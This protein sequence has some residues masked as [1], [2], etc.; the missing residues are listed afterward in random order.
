MMSEYDPAIAPAAGAQPRL[1]D[2][3]A[4]ALGDTAYLDSGA[5]HPML[6]ASRAAVA[7]YLAVRSLVGADMPPVAADRILARF[8]AL[9]NAQPDEVAFVQSTTTAEHLIVDGL[10]L[11]DSDAHI[12]TDTLHFVGSIPLYDGLARR[13]AHV[14]WVRP[15]DGRILL[16]DFERALTAQ[17]S[18][19]AL[20]SVSSYNGFEHDLAAVCKLAHAKGAL[21]YADIV[22]SAGCV[23]IDVAAAGVDF[24]AC[25]S[26]KWLMGEFGLGFVYISSKAASRLRRK[27]YG[28]GGAARFQSHIYPLDPPG[29]GIADVEMHGNATGCFA[30]GAYNRVAAIALDQSTAFIEQLGVA[31]INAHACELTSCLKE[32]LAKRGYT[33]LTPRESRAPIV[34]CLMEDAQSLA[35]RLAE[36]GVR[37]TLDRNRFRVSPSIF[38]NLDDVERLLGALPRN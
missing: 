31:R 18:F 14:S 9:I 2:R 34:T 28:Y 5:V 26:Y 16:E 25:S 37:I 36:A 11:F 3:A 7:D 35:G 30:T 22:H 10:G 38:N 29:E 23:P 8:A 24:A 6:R 17:T 20:S 13:G 21:V 19:V 27:R 15:R 12:V 33:V 1:P 32:E 4:F